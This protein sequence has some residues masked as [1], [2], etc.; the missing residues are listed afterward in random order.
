MIGVVT[1]LES[2]Q[3][4]NPTDLSKADF[5]KNVEN[6]VL[7][8]SLL[9]SSV[10]IKSNKIIPLYKLINNVY[11]TKNQHIKTYYSNLNQLQIKESK[12]FSFAT[13]I[14]IPVILLIYLIIRLKI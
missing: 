5:Q 7:M 2:Y 13:S 6:N 4:L 11:N 9:T 14:K 8:F 3:D 10:L 12:L 1:S